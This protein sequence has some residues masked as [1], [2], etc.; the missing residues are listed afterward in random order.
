M[1]SQDLG[2]GM[3][4]CEDIPALLRFGWS[5]YLPV[6]CHLAG[7]T[8]LHYSPVITQHGPE[9][10]CGPEGK[11]HSVGGSLYCI[12]VSKTVTSHLK[13]VGVYGVV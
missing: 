9:A 5:R 4:N 3:R 2:A 10:V 13:E 12:K 11:V 6:M 8:V 7:M 1:L